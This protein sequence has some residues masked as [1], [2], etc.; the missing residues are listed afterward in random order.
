M[1]D[2]RPRGDAGPRHVRGAAR[3]APVAARARGPWRIAVTDPSMRPAVEPGDWLLVDP[4]T[5]RWP[6]RGAIVLF[7]EPDDGT[8]AI[9]RVA[10]RPGDWVPFADG[11]LRMG[12]DEAW[13]VGDASDEDVAAAGAGV[14]VDSRR[15]G[16]VPVRLLVGRAWFRYGPP[17]RPIGVLPGAPPDLLSRGR[18]A[19]LPAPGAPDA[20]P[21]D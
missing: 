10:A 15:Y 4:L 14:P 5:V 2:D 3:A 13:L 8:L 12:D 9:K 19:A 21:G 20:A 16:P 7:H 18:H 11:W 1:S 6:R 17:G